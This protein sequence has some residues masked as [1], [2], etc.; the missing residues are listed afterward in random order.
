VSDFAISAWIGLGY[1]AVLMIVSTVKNRRIMY[2]QVGFVVGAI[3]SCQNIFPPIRL[4]SFAMTDN[5]LPLPDPLAGYDK[6]LL[7][8]GAAAGMVTLV[9]LY[10]FFVLANKVIPK[11]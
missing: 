9:S 3:V 6:Y 8:A 10:S 1:A 5:H 11:S 2:E 4:I 7:V